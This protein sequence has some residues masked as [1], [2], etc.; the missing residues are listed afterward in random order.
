VGKLI[1]KSEEFYVKERNKNDEF[2]KAYGG[3]SSD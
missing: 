3:R 2:A 1:S